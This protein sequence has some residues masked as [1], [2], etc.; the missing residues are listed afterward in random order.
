M[1]VLSANAFCKLILFTFEL[2]GQ[3]VAKPPLQQRSDAPHE[4]EPH[5]PSWSPKATPRALS[6]WALRTKN[7]EISSLV[8]GFNVKV[9]HLQCVLKVIFSILD[10][11]FFHTAFDPKATYCNLSHGKIYLTYGPF[12]DSTY[13]VEAIVNEMFQILAHSNLPHQLVLVAIHAS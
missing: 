1:L 10:F 7:I 11:S 8:Y 6:N 4:E 9:L 2:P 12:R 5:S 3:Q 13:R